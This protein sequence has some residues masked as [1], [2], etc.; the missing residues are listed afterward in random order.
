MKKLLANPKM[1]TKNEHKEECA[2]ESAY[3][4]AGDVQA[5]HAKDAD[6]D[7]EADQR[8]DQVL[9]QVPLFLRCDICVAHFGFLRSRG[10]CRDFRKYY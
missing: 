2:F 8:D 9:D 10:K 3:R 7:R 6:L 1:S 4:K 5:E